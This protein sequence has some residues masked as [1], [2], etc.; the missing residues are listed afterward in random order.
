MTVAA[1]DAESADV[2]LVAERHRLRTSYILFSHVRRT[3]DRGDEP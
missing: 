3:V 1:I 2:M